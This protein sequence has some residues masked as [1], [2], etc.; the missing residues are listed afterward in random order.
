MTR[1]E[2]LRDLRA[3]LVEQLNKVAHA[4]FQQQLTFDAYNASRGR[5]KMLTD[6]IRWLDDEMKRIGGGDDDD[7]AV[8]ESEPAVE[9]EDFESPVA[10]ATVKRR[11]QNRQPR[12]WG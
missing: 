7:G 12:Q 2:F 5:Y 1:I 8:S 9:D 4:G 10:A 11:Q 3:K 6:L